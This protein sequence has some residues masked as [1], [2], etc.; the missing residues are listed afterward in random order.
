MRDPLELE[1]AEIEEL[2]LAPAEFED[3]MRLRCSEPDKQSTS[4]GDTPE[5]QGGRADRQGDLPLGLE[6]P[7]G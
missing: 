5:T 4:G 2:L 7:G 1:P 3:R 6:D